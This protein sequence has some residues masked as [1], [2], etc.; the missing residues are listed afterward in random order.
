MEKKQTPQGS[1]YWNKEGAYQTQYDVLYAKL[2]PDMG[3]ADSVNGE[4]IRG[5]SR[6]SYD[7]FNNGN[8]NVRREIPIHKETYFG[9]DN[10]EDEYD[11][12]DESEEYDYDID[13]YYQKFLDLIDE[14]IP[15]SRHI[16][17]EVVDII[18]GEHDS[19]MFS[20]TNISK[21][22]AMVDEVMYY[23]LTNNDKP[24]SYNYNKN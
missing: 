18:L 23:I 1:S 5:I 4:L 16:M 10:E 12:F 13:P 11:S 17:K 3:A 9:G 7:Y 15:S 20:N 24:L 6:L 2:V 14:N 19:G 8:C 21:Y 22:S